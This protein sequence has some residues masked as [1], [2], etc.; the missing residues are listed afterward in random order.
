[1]AGR[2]SRRGDTQLRS[3]LYEAALHVLSRSRADTALRRRGL[4]PRAKAG[5]KRAVV[6][7]ARKLAVVLHAIGSKGVPFEPRLPA[8]ATP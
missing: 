4:A 1:M 5:F 8:A 6:A 7:V 3:Y 2:V